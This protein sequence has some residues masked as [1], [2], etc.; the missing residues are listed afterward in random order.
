MARKAITIADPTPKKPVRRPGP[1]VTENRLRKVEERRRQIF[2]GALRCFEQKGY[3][4]TTINDLADA[5]GVSSGLIYQYFNDKRDV[6][7]QVILEILEAYNRDLPG[8]ISR[9]SDPLDRFQAAAIAYFSVIEKRIDATLM[10][11]RETKLLDR[12]QINTL[13]AKELQTNDLIL[14]CVKQCIDQGLCNTDNAELT[15]YS[16]I[17]TAHM[18]ALKNWRLREIC[19]HREYTVHAISMIMNQMLNDDGK[20][21][22]KAS[23]LLSKWKPR[24]NS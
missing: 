24:R 12:D 21:A 18:W 16:V 4:E 14:Q 22:W 10:S 15:T 13:K 9:Y 5:A 19:T 8:A 23:N 2:S 3:H 20:A 1:G 6:L 7:F 11:Y 17:T